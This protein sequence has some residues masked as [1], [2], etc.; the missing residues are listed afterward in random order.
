[1]GATRCALRLFISYGISFVDIHVKRMLADK[2]LKKRKRLCR[3]PLLNF[4]VSRCNISKWPTGGCH[5]SL[6]VCRWFAACVHER[7][8]GA[9]LFT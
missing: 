6:A 7:Y 9:A 1:M 8:G 2:R 3:C 5:Y 4:N